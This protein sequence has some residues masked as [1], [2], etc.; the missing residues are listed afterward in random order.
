M[1]NTPRFK[2]THNGQVIGWFDTEIEAQDA[3]TKADDAD[4]ANWLNEYYR[5]C[6]S[7]RNLDSNPMGNAE[8]TY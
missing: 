5:Q 1:K 7:Q 6:R 3:L 8:G 2:A 4:E